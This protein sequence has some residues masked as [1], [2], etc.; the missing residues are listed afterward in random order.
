MNKYEYVSQND[1]VDQRNLMN[2]NDYVNN[3]ITTAY[4]IALC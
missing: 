1:K 2:H 4:S 3:M